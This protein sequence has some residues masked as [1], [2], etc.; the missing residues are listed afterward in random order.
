MKNQIGAAL[1]ER[2]LRASKENKKFKIIVIIPTIPC[3]AGELDKA[4]GIRAILAYQFYSISRGE[5]SIFGQLRTKGVDASEYISFYHLRGYDRIL[6]PA[7]VVHEIERRSGVTYHQS[8]VALSRVLNGDA[9]QDMGI[10]QKKGEPKG[11]LHTESVQLFDPG[12]VHQHVSRAVKE[13]NTPDPVPGA[14]GLSRKKAQRSQTDGP[15]TFS[16]TQD[17][18]P[19]VPMPKTVAEARAIL[20]KFEAGAREVLTDPS[21]QDSVAKD[22]SVSQPQPSSEPWPDHSLS[23]EEVGAW[24]TEEIYIHSKLMIVDDRRVI[25]GSA[26]LNDRSQCGDRDSEIAVLIEDGEMIDSLMDGQPYQAS[27]FAFEFRR[28]LWLQHLGHLPPQ[29]VNSETAQ[30]FP[31]DHMR[32][33]LADE[34][35]GNATRAA[36]EEH[37]HLVQ[38]PL[39][40]DLE[41]LWKDRA[42]TNTRVYEEVFHPVPSDRVATWKTYHNYFPSYPPVV[43]GHVADTHA[44]PHWVREHLDQIQGSLV[45]FS[46]HF[47]NEEDLVTMDV[48]VNNLTLDI[49]L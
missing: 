18:I 40:E 11:P 24:V 37:A 41:R 36:E 8:Q 7:S 45:N 26:N 15:T 38:D 2:I 14:Q 35:D 4:A 30:H 20:D 34:G 42:G 32:P 23:G 28:H 44:D 27:K 21:V 13:A 16:G 49:Y 22:M 9:E 3:F 25:I 39:S 48:E 19:A 46:H 43:T 10:D 5:N 29:C 31:H 17:T 47:M 33:V 6:Y 1:V 12:E